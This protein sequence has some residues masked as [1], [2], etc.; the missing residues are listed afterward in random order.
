M[1]GT[2]QFTRHT[3]RLHMKPGIDWQHPTIL[4]CDL[5]LPTYKQV[6]LHASLRDRQV[7]RWMGCCCE[8]PSWGNAAEYSKQL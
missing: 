4:E 3:S 1:K 7:C 6:L 5:H 8:Q 2:K